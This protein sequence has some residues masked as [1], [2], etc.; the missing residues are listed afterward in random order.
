MERLRG[1]ARELVD[2]D[3]SISRFIGILRAAVAYFAG[4]NE[5]A[6]RFIDETLAG[7]DE[8]ARAAVRMFRASLAENDGD[9]DTMRRETEIALAEFR[10]IGERWGLASTLRVVAQLHTLDGELDEAR[11]AYLEALRLAAELNSRED[12]GFLRGRLADVELRRGNFDEARDHMRRARQNA[13]ENGAP[14]ESVFTMAMLGAIE[15][16]SG[17]VAEARSLQRE[18]MRRVSSMPEGHP[19]QGHLRAIL[20]AIGA[21]ISFED[22]DLE[23]ARQLARD[24]FDAATATHDMPILAAVGVTLAE[25]VTGAG[26]S[27]SAAVMLG[28]AARLRGAD[29]PTAR[30]IA[31]LTKRLRAA[32]G[33][34]RFESC[35]AQGKALDRTAAI[36][37]LT[38]SDAAA[39]VGGTARS[40]L[41]FG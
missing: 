21:R 29:D 9:V 32:L 15:Q 5:L 14:W 34:E 41:W 38:P 13:E 19:A 20:L 10:R 35:Y 18:A 7:E 6:D 8:W 17:N 28:A 16:Q 27:A 31:T 1:L 37:R 25:I 2:F 12:E 23:A 4:D 40:S 36:E 39:T 33:D 26:D 30:D 11:D 22:G 24:G 3:P